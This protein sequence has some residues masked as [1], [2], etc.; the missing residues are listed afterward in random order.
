MRRTSDSFAERETTLVNQ[1]ENVPTALRLVAFFSLS[2]NE[3]LFC[4][5]WEQYYCFAMLWV[6]G[7]TNWKTASRNKDKMEENNDKK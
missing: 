5:Y 3:R 6:F 2:L 4:G 1:F 7:I